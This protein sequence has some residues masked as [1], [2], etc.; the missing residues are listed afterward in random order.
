MS[1]CN[2]ICVAFMSCTVK[3]N[4]NL[5]TGLVFYLVYKTYLTT[6]KCRLCCYLTVLEA[7]TTERRLPALAAVAQEVVNTVGQQLS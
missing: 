1:K 4:I 5:F 2:D 7:L 3:H 6:I